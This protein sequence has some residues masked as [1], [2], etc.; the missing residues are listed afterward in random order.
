[1]EIINQ[2]ERRL[3]R[4]FNKALRQYQLIDDND[5]VLI[6][7]SGGKDSLFLVDRLARRRSVF[8][9]RFQVEAVHV[10]MTNI[11]YE[12]SAEYLHNFCAE[13][14]VPFHLL[15][16]SFD[17]STD[18]RKEP[19]FLCSW[20]RRK[21]I[22]N[23]A[24]AEGFQKIA[25]GHHMDDIL[26]T[27]L[28]NLLFQGRFEGMPVK[29][30]MKKMPVTIIRPLCLCHEADILLYAQS[31]G[32]EKQK[33]LCPYETETHRSTISSLY[34]QMELLNLETRYSIWH[35]LEREGK[36]FPTPTTL[37][38]ELSQYK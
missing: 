14:E 10:R 3:N 16:T 25:L 2:V 4:C 8:R 23:L 37:N 17:A 38:S 7:L 9:P 6:A 22:F 1:M 28:M 24:Q 19:C 30:P 18:R 13:R 21:Q 33:R 29:L 31:V 26:H 15:T 5:R 11:D 12:S 27:T 35:A 34:Q 32:F 36:L 20:N